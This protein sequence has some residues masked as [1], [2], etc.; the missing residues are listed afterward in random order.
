ML[1]RK[2][3]VRV[4]MIDQDVTFIEGGFVRLRRTCE[5]WRNVQTAM[6][7]KSGAKLPRRQVMSFIL[8]NEV[9]G[10]D[11]VLVDGGDLHVWSR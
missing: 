1:E 7:K 8:G 6:K 3:W 2:L 4:T 5:V 9:H 10:L 11:K